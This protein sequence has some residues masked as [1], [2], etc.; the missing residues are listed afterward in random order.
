M[1][2]DEAVVFADNMQTY[3]VERKTTEEKGVGFY[4]VGFDNVSVEKREELQAGNPYPTA[5]ALE[6]AAT[7]NTPDENEITIQHAVAICTHSDN[8]I[9]LQTGG[10]HHRTN[11]RKHDNGRHYTTTFHEVFTNSGWVAYDRFRY[12]VTRKYCGCN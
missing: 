1:L 2:M 11:F 8:V 9:S 5:D 7:G 10:G 6:F 4:F 12:S 3:E